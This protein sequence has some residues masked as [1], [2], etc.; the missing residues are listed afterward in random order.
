MLRKYGCQPGLLAPN[1][2]FHYGY[3]GRF[4]DAH[5]LSHGSLLHKETG[6]KIYNKQ[7]CLGNA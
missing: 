3:S 7:I 2:S 6:V 4:D 1:G 5:M